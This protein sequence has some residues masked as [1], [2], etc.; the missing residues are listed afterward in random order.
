MNKLIRVDVQTFM[1]ES[2]INHGYYVFR[3]KIQNFD[4]KSHK[5][6][7]SCDKVASKSFDLPA[8]ETINASLPLPVTN[9]YFGNA[10]NILVDNREVEHLYCPM[11]YN[12]APFEHYYYTSY[13][14]NDTTTLDNNAFMACRSLRRG[15]A[16]ADCI[17]AECDCKN[18]PQ[19]RLD[20]SCLDFILL[21]PLELSAA[22]AG[23]QT[24]LRQFVSGGGI[25]W[26]FDC[27][28]QKEALDKI[29]WI[30]QLKNDTNMNRKTADTDKS[31]FSEYSLAFGRV[32][33]FD[34]TPEE[35][36]KQDGTENSNSDKNIL[37]DIYEYS[38]YRSFSDVSWFNRGILSEW[39]KKFPVV[40]DIGIPRAG[41]LFVIFLFVLL[42]GPVNLFLLT[43]HNKRIWLL[44]TVPVLSFLFA[45]A[46]LLYVTLSEGFKTETRLCVIDYLDQRDG[47]YAS[48]TQM[49]VYARTSPSNVTFDAEDELNIIERIKSDRLNIDWTSGKQVIHSTFAPV[50]NPAYYK[51][52]KTGT[53][54]LNLDFDFKAAY[55]YV[56]NGLGKDIELLYVRDADGTL[57]KAENIGA[58]E[59]ATLTFSNSLEETNYK[60]VSEFQSLISEPNWN[61]TASSLNKNP[62][63]IPP[64]CYVAKFRSP[65]PFS[66]KGISY[67]IE[68]RTT[69]F[70]LGRF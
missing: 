23:V 63:N 4:S 45:G 2:K 7:L 56:V 20:Y 24:A 61:V 25:L 46:I 41:I 27:E 54:R 48:M 65:G 32:F 70:L 35:F 64:N 50:R 40:D 62:G 8:S 34:F 39:Q 14:H 16:E 3:C 49:G 69:A 13:S 67:A 6:T 15:L 33:L 43:K 58:G 38:G 44:V 47:T 1:T 28:K 26:L 10:V 9:P 55:P 12:G 31:H 22:P 57:W 18:W 51:I 53:S 60:T 37:L 11:R 68:K 17:F 30:T 36:L 21:T 29:E 59:K 52:R 66:N 5:V 19:D 42:A